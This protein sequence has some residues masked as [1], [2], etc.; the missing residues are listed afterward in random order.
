[1]LNKEIL[2]KKL[3]QTIT[4]PNGVLYS[5]LTLTQKGTGLSLFLFPD[6]IRATASVLGRASG[7]REIEITNAPEKLLN[8]VVFAGGSAMGL[9]AAS[10]VAEYLREK[11]L[12]HKTTFARVPLVASAVVYDLFYKG[13]HYPTEEDGYNA[14]LDLKKEIAEEGDIGAGCGTMC[15]KLS[16]EFI[17]SGVGFAPIDDEYARGFAFCV[18][19]AMGAPDIESVE[20]YLEMRRIHVKVKKK[21]L[22]TTAPKKRTNLNTILSFILID[23]DLPKE[24]L[25]KI[26]KLAARAVPEFI[27]PAFTDRD[28]DVLFLATTATAKYSVPIIAPLALTCQNALY[29]A[30]VRSLLFSKPTPIAGDIYEFLS[31]KN[32]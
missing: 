15:N 29:E 16:G 8:S 20:R 17:K 19:N 10:G 11:G 1:M 9:A 22:K 3:E 32:R 6:G 14:C 24:T 5:A 25:L 27:S 30:L 18:N 28:G 26:G 13:F 31:E 23:S 12:G 4:L 21:K 7:T 2:K